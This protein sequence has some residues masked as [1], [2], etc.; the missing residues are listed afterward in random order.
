MSET[1]ECNKFEF[2]SFDVH[3]QY[4]FTN[5]KFFLLVLV[6]LNAFILIF[7]YYFFMFD[8]FLQVI[9]F[10]IE[11]RPRMMSRFSDITDEF[12]SKFIDG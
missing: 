2:I 8:V 1:L 9:M 5:F 4:F 10:P 7:I 11:G 12:I 6:F 3:Y